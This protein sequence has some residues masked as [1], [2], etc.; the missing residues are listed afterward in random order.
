[1]AEYT[2]VSRDIERWLR[3]DVRIRKRITQI[4]NGV[5]I[6]RFRPRAD[7]RVRAELGIGAHAF[8]AGI[9]ARLDPIKDHETLLESFARLHEKRPDSV[10]L[11]VGE[12][13][14]A[15]ALQ[16]LAGPGVRLLGHREDVPELMGALDVFVLPSRNEG[17][18]NTILEAMAA[19]LPV[20]ASRV[21][22]TPELLDDGVE[23]RLFD[24]G[25]VGGLFEALRGYLD[26]ASL[27]ES[28][29]AAGRA[30]VCE[31]ASIRAMVEAYEA[32]WRRTAAS[33]SGS[34]G[35][36]SAEDCR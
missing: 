16:R 1:V 22:G 20:V 3:D 28:H 27:R 31:R 36:D 15:D 26:D 17:I 6:D 2:C 33:G 10:L 23:G 18:S 9:V 7:S 34:D 24:A 30:R 29:G 8:V 11:V 21:G 14:H 25:D 19:G 13:P 35:S 32:V 5:D 4:Y 12:G